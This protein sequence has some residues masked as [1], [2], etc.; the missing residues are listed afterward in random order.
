MVVVA[1]LNPLTEDARFIIRPTLS[2]SPRAMLLF[3]LLVCAFTLV[4]NIGFIL[5]GAWL[6]LPFAGLELLAL[7]LAQWFVLKLAEQT[8]VI[9]IKGD[10]IH[11]F[12]KDHKVSKE[13]QFHRYWT[14]VVLSRD[15]KSWYPNKLFIRSHG[16]SVEIGSCLTDQ[17]RETLSLDLKKILS[18]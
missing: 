6:V 17:E 8:E 4:I 16:R 2:L 11:V 1:E 7:G 13:W 5:A 15:I 14:R 9:T 18:Q 3:Y 10:D 12:Y